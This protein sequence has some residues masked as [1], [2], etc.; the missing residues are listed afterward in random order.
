M[1]NYSVANIPKDNFLPPPV[2]EPPCLDETWDSV[3]KKQIDSRSS[4][5]C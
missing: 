5:A 4:R 1:E 3:I 2:T